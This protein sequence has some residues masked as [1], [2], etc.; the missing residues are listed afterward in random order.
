VEEHEQCSRPLT[1]P[2]LPTRVLD[3]DGGTSSPENLRLY[4]T[5][6]APGRYVALSHRW[7]AYTP[8][9]TTKTLLE[10][11]C[12]EILLADLPRTFRDAIVVTRKLGV[13][14]LWID[15]LCIVQDDPQD[16]LRE[17]AL[18]G[19]IFANSYCTLAATSAKDSN[20]GLFLPRTV[21]QSVKLTDSSGDSPVSF[22]S[23]IQDHFERDLDDGDLNSRGWVLQERL[24]SPRM[25]HF[26]AVQTFW[27]CGSDRYSEDC[28]ENPFK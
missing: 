8:L 25:I 24:L 7:G 2:K 10:I 3:V 4:H 16:W 26:T 20:G 27:E 6:R 14:Y 13:R 1:S 9:K 23:G 12:E 28:V 15:S 21:S 18:M 22:Y 5:G 11:H 17:S 19:E